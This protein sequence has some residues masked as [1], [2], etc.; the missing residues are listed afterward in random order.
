M[1]PFLVATLLFAMY[2]FYVERY[3]E[4]SWREFVTDFLG[5]NSVN[6]LE[7]VNKR[8]VK[9]VSNTPETVSGNLYNRRNPEVKF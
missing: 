8:W 6:R 2:V 7:V 5:K 3:K 9:V 4:I 1:A